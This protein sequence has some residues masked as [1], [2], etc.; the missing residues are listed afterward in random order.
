MQ[1]VVDGVNHKW[2]EVIDHTEYQGTLTERNTEEVEQG[3]RSQRT[4]QN[5]DPHGKNK[6]YDHCFRPVQFCVAQ[7]PCCRIA[8]Q[9]TDNGGNNGNTDGIDKGI[10]SFVVLKKLRKV[11]QSQMSAVIGESIDHDKE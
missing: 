1:S 4:Y 9:D 10:D 8:Q 7:Y 11:F 2:Y 6:Q 3:Y 5:V